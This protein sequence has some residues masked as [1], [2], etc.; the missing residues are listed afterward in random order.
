MINNI[1]SFFKN[2]KTKWESLQNKNTMSKILCKAK[3]KKGTPCQNNSKTNSQFCTRHQSTTPIPFIPQLE[4]PI[5]IQH[6]DL[7]MGSLTEYFPNEIIREILKHLNVFD[8]VN[9]SMTNTSCG[10]FVK[11]YRM[12]PKDTQ[13]RY[14]N[15][16]DFFKE[17]Q[18]IVNVEKAIEY[19]IPVY[20]GQQ[21]IIYPT[22]FIG[23]KKIDLLMRKGVKIKM[24]EDN[25]NISWINNKNEYPSFEKNFIPLNKSMKHLLDSKLIKWNTRQMYLH[26]EDINRRFEIYRSNHPDRII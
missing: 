4:D 1:Y 22:K 3:T 8:L 20:E 6:S 7:E 2:F 21:L 10:R 12:I 13:I 19:D 11:A 23:M 16:L 5:F 26:V 14:K 15:F 18:S 24:K 9:F 25:G 17:K